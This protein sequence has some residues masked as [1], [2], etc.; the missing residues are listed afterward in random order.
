ML[1]SYTVNADEEG[2]GTLVDLKIDLSGDTPTI[3][4]VGKVTRIK[5][6]LP[7]TIHRIATEF[8]EIGEQERE[9]AGILIAHAQG[10]KIICVVKKR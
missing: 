9:M 8:K 3:N 4:C 6:S 5:Q 2:I 1:F 10:I 7:H